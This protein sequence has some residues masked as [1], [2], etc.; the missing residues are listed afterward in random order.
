[1]PIFDWDPEKARR[2]RAKH[3]ITFEVA[4]RVWDDPLQVVLPDR[5]GSGE[6]RW[7]AIGVAGPVVVLSSFTPTG[8]EMD[9]TLFG[10][11][12]LGRPR[13]M[14]GGCMK[15]REFSSEEL[16]QLKRLKAL[17]DDQIDLSDIPEITEEQWKLARRPHLYRPLKRAVTIRLDADVVSWFKEHASD[18]GYQTEINRVLRQHVAKAEAAKTS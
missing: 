14:K 10:S 1:M 6:E 16:A 18:R 17:P 7:L 2:N 11:S 3:G 15:K 12:A 9:T 5:S 4:T 13:R 8:D